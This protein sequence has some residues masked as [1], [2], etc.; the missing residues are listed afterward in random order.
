M[1]RR[2]KRPNNRRPRKRGRSR[3]SLNLIEEVIDEINQAAKRN[4]LETLQIKTSKLHHLLTLRTNFDGVDFG[5]IDLIGV[6]LTDVSLLRAKFENATGRNVNFF[7]SEMSQ[8]IFDNAYLPDSSFVNC[9]LIDSSFVGASVPS[10]DFQKSDLQ[11][12]SFVGA[13]LRFTNFQYANLTDANFDGAD[14]QGANLSNAILHGVD[15]KNVKLQGA[16]FDGAVFDFSGGGGPGV[17]D[18]G[19]F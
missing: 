2:R 9:R 5:R 10:T 1:A 14:L 18:V 4:D 15:L 7:A 12:T 3:V 19:D 17:D 11:R 8:A 6:R 16:V 13:N